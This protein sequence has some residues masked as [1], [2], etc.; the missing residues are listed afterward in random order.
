MKL[1]ANDAPA[2]ALLIRAENISLMRD[3]KRILQDVTLEVNRHD[4]ITIVGP[5]GAGKTM[6]LRIMAGLL[7]PDRGKVQRAASLSIGYMPQ[8]IVP[9]PTLPITVK[10]FIS[11]R[12]AVQP[13]A[14]EMIAQQLQI[15]ELMHQLLHELSGGEL[16]RVLLAR[17]MIGKPD[18][19]VLDE[20][21]QNLDIA[22]QLTFYKLL[23]DI[24]AQQQV[25]ILM[26]SHDLH[27]VMASSR[28]VVCLYHHICCEGPP[29]MVAND[30]EFL[31]LFGSDTARMMAVYHHD[32]H[33]THQHTH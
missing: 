2:P 25:S 24:Y 14:L 17:A 33:H 13:H 7:K 20:P 18:L 19:L 11:L 23:N 5:N 15:E 28:K 31:R 6:L 10:R 4:F 9:D 30:P 3:G 1:A 12:K 21:A 32:H 16:Q 26:V 8:K 22:S 27:L 29:Q